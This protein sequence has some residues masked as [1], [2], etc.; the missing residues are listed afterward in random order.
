MVF[1]VKYQKYTDQL[2][3]GNCLFFLLWTM[4]IYN[5]NKIVRFLSSC[6]NVS[7]HYVFVKS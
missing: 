6:L 3:L 2:L 1:C 7:V 5:N 4:F